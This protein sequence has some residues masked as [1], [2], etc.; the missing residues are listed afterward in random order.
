MPQPLALLGSQPSVCHRPGPSP[1][2]VSHPM[3]MQLNPLQVVRTVGGSDFP[4]NIGNVRRRTNELIRVPRRS[5][6]GDRAQHQGRRGRP[7]HT[8]RISCAKRPSSRFATRLRVQRV[9]PLQTGL[10]A[11][12]LDV[13]DFALETNGAG[14]FSIDARRDQPTRRA[15]GLGHAVISVLPPFARVTRQQTFQTSNST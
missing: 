1:G 14:R 11:T 3:D 4:R 5:S 2:Q 10:D 12:S 9:C 8:G 15:S 13:G 6:L 7:E